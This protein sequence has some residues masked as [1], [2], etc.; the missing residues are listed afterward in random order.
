MHSVEDKY[1][2]K[3]FA[4]VWSSK[5]YRELMHNLHKIILLSIHPPRNVLYKDSPPTPLSFQNDLDNIKPR[6]NRTAS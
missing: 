3:S 6:S 5:N 2:P 4:N 1:Y